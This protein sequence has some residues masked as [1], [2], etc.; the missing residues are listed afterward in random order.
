[1]KAFFLRVLR[2][3]VVYL[4][5][6]SAGLQR[7]VGLAAFFRWVMVAFWLHVR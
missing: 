7:L 2:G 6:M 1:M 4:F 3:F 5:W